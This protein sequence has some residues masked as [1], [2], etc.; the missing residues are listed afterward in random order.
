[1]VV[2]VGGAVIVVLTGRNW[3]DCAI[4]TRLL[5]LSSCSGTFFCFYLLRFDLICALC[6]VFWSYL[7]FFCRPQDWGILESALLRVILVLTLSPFLP[8]VPL[9]CYLE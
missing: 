6:F 1:M 5:F 2:L 8:F 7:V 3:G 4:G 9:P